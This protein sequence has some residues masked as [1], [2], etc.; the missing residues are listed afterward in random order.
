MPAQVTGAPKMAEGGGDRKAGGGAPPVFISYASQDATV[1]AALV[2]ALERHGM[3][4]W[5]APRNV[6]AG[7]LYADAIVRAISGA[8]AFVVVLSE[9]AIASSHVGKEIE[10]A[11]SKK[12][13]IIALRIDAAPL[14][15]AL[16]YFLSE[17]QWI[18]AQA[19]NMEAAY[20]RLLDA[21]REP[22]QTAQGTKFGEPLRT[23]AARAGRPE[24]RRKRILLV[25][26]SAFV[27]AILGAILVDEFWLGRHVSA[28]QATA[29]AIGST[30]TAGPM[31][32]DKSIAVLPFVDMSEKKDQEYFADG[33]AEEIL[34]LL[35]KIPGLT[36]I[37]RTSSFQ[38]KGKNEDLRI[39]GK[40]LGA[41]YVLEGSVR[42]SGDRVRI[43][44]QLINAQTG[45]H[46]WSETYD[47]PFSDVLKM[48]D[49]IAAALVR[50]LQL[51]SPRLFTQLRRL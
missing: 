30:V 50:A 49:E 41:A 2:E 20:A 45:A 48:Q 5:I 13:P 46:R 11:S 47:R 27:A 32:S 17:S 42:K 16:E 3:A 23:G 9:N 26:G 43:T 8:K 10:R 14:T 28:A 37:G 34:D 21:F 24:A 44:T 51:M 18:E 7:A 31:I 36:V 12:R 22:E 38:F 29:R 6:K 35:A 25:A 15:P 39:I 19:G 4:C 40:K 1:A 33:M